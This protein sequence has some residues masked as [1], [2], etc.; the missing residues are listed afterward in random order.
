MP[1]N[2]YVLR[3]QTNRE[4]KIAESLDRRVKAAGAENLIYSVMVPTERVTEIRGGKKRITEKKTY[5]GYLMVEV[6]SDESGGIP[7][8]TWY[9]IRETPGSGDFVGP[10]NMP[11]AMSDQEVEKMTTEAEQKEEKPTVKIDFRVGEGVK[12]K[13]GPFQ[14]FDGVVEEVFPEKGMVKVIVMIFGRPTPVELEYWQIE[15]L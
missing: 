8:S 5:P 9:L 7:E 12:I 3:V 14:N 6:E 11:V 1:R 15:S 13:E 4:N 10:A 2:W